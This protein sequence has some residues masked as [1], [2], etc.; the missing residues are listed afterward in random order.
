MLSTLVGTFGELNGFTPI[1][2]EPN[3]ASRRQGTGY[4]TAIVHQNPKNPEHTAE[5]SVKVSF[6]LTEDADDKETNK[7]AR[8]INH[9]LFPKTLDTYQQREPL[10]QVPKSE[11]LHSLGGAGDSQLF[12]VGYSM[13]FD[14]KQLPEPQPQFQRPLKLENSE[15]ITGTRKAQE[16]VQKPLGLDFPQQQEFFSNSL[17]EQPNRYKNSFTPKGNINLFQSSGS[18]NLLSQNGVSPF[19]QKYYQALEGFGSAPQSGL[20][21]ITKPWHNLNSGGVE[22]LRSTEL[23]PNAKV[24]DSTG[25]FKQSQQ[26][27]HAGA[28]QKSVGFD[29]SNALNADGKQSGQNIPLLQHNTNGGSAGFDG[30]LY[31]KKLLF[32]L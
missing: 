9:Y 4:T 32:Y 18:K 25:A 15:I 16:F 12:N 28:L 21:P 20:P 24:F 30:N 6:D 7:K 5:S 22:I 31:G 23:S 29:Y 8:Q 13:S 17:Q 10:V 11:L 1:L 3:E 14:Q 2:I 19:K 26:F 27:D